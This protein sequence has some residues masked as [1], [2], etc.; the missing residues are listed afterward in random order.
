M[1]YRRSWTWGEPSL[2]GWGGT[3][4]L[5][6]FFFYLY[7]SSW[8]DDIGPFFTKSVRKT[9][10]VIS[11][12]SSLWWKPMRTMGPATESNLSMT[13]FSTMWRFGRKALIWLLAISIHLC[14]WPQ[15]VFLGEHWQKWEL[16]H[17]HWCHH[18][19]PLY[20]WGFESFKMTIILTKNFNEWHSAKIW[21]QKCPSIFIA[22]RICL[23]F[24][25]TGDC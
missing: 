25:R 2:R 10:N 17:N 3:F 14:A 21:I 24:T 18:L 8:E 15:Y 1:W 16:F 6:S 20:Q 12:T 19:Q 13:S 23:D 11:G 7:L 4:H 22:D 5:S 9:R